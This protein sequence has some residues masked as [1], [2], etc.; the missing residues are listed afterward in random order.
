LIYRSIEGGFSV[1]LQGGTIGG[2]GGVLYAAPASIR[3]TGLVPATSRSIQFK[4]QTEPGAFSVSL[5]GVSLPYFNLST[6][7][8]YSVYGA[9]VSAFAG[10]TVELEFSL[11]RL[12][13]TDYSNWN[14]D[15]IQFSDLA[16]PEPGVAAFVVVGGVLLWRFRRR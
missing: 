2:P 13:G 16:I 14:I 8:G 12:P 9:D 10:R 4:A 5:D 7:S 11:S 15:S 3:Q 6:G 1:L